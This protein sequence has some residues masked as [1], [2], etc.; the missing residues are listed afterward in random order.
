M[1]LWRV[2]MPTQNLFRL[3]LLMM[4]MLRN[5]LT[6]V[7]CR[8]G[9]WHLVIKK[10]LSRLWAPVLVKIMKLKLRR[11]FEAEVKSVFCCW[12]L[13]EVMKI[14]LGRHSEAMF[15][16]DLDI[17][18]SFLSCCLVENMVEKMKSDKDLFENLWYDLK[19]LL[20]WP[21]LN[22]RVRCAFGNVFKTL[23]T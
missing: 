2:K 12:S 8:F 5:V 9:S 17:W 20:W 11:V 21:E 4:L 22:P 6:I 3:L 7:W 16:Q 13:L 10:F 1:W 15:G 18:L 19:K 23:I 14:I